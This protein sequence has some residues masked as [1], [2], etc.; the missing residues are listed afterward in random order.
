MLSKKCYTFM[1]VALAHASCV[2]SAVIDLNGFASVTGG[3]TIS[4]GETASGPAT[5][6]VD[7]SHGGTYD[8]EVSFRPDS[9]YGL[10]IIADLGSGLSATGQI[11]GAGA[12][13]FNAEFNWA[14]ISYELTPNTKLSAGRMGYPLYYYSDFL[15][16]R[17]AYHW[18]RA[19]ADTYTL[20][21][22][23]IE[24][25]KLRHRYD[26]GAV[27]GDVQ[28]FAGASESELNGFPGAE[29]FHHE[30]IVGIVGSIANEWAELR[31]VSL[32][33][34]T[35]HEDDEELASDSEFY[36]LT[37]KFQFGSL[38]VIGELTHFEFDTP[39]TVT[40][41]VLPTFL[42]EGDSGYVSLGYAFGAWTPHVTFSA[43]ETAITYTGF[44]STEASNE[45]VTVG[46]RWDF[47]PSAAL[48]IEYN[49]SEDTSDDSFTALAGDAYEVDTFA[50][51]VDFVF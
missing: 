49:S 51:G 29:P 8:D 6:F 48:K 42:D 22:N 15:N 50:V 36:G 16:V 19:P 23:E 34:D 1:A 3:M 14:F 40:R 32:V 26:L 43:R 25:L 45:T 37:A 30:N 41:N 18:L 13:D 7:G 28:L 33:A 4:E 17:Y 11:V 2:N 47:H 9:L 44:G 38:F 31:L 12:N 10:Q 21:I 27:N 20:P 24:G 46:V 35:Y 5:Y 39:V